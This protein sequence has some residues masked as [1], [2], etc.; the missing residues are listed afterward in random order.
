MNLN[1][2]Y[3]VL[4]IF[5]CELCLLA[6]LVLL[7]YAVFLIPPKQTSALFKNLA[8]SCAC[9]RSAKSARKSFACHSSKIAVCN[10][11]IC[12]RSETPHPCSRRYAVTLILFA[13]RAARASPLLLPSQL[14]R[15]K[16]L[17]YN[18]MLL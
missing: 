12:H 13:R 1:S 14:L 7:R 9:H 16:P 5:G 18:P 6:S 10:S 8:K 3:N 11:F 4:S 15:V 17:G 2:K